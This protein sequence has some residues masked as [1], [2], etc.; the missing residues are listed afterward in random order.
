MIEIGG[1]VRTSRVYQFYLHIVNKIRKDADL[2]L[3]H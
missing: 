1:P 3:D 2:Q